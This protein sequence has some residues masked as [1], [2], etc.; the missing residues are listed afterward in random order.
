MKSTNPLV[1]DHRKMGSIADIILRRELAVTELEK[2]LTAAAELH[3]E[4][5]QTLVALRSAAKDEGLEN[6]NLPGEMDPGDFQ[7]RVYEF[8]RAKSIGLPVGSLA[9]QITK[10]HKAL[11]TRLARVEGRK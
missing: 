8:F 5:F 4:A 3:A 10:E 9:D 2:T 6:R 7:A 11:R 1:T